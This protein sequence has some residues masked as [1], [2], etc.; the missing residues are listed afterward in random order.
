MNHHQ[1]PLSKK[2]YEVLGSDYYFI[3]TSEMSEEQRNLG[4][5]DMTA[6]FNIYLNSLLF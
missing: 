3:A 6:P 2:F 5:E 1:M 4:Y